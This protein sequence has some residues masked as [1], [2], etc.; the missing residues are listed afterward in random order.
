[1]REKDFDHLYNLEEK[2]W[3]F[4]GMRAIT[5]VIV[6]RE[7]RGRTLRILD[8]GCGTGYNI[9]H[10]EQGGHSVFA[11]DLAAE[12]ITGV[13]KRGFRKVCQASITDI[14]YRS[15]SFDVVFS[16]DV[17]Q[18]VSAELAKQAIREMY[19]VLKPG[20]HLYIRVAAFEWLRSSHDQEL[21][22]VHRYTRRELRARLEDAGFEALRHTYANTFLF[23]VV[24]LRRFVK[25]FGIGRGSDVKPLPTALAWVDPLFR[26]SLSI[27][28]R[29]LS[30]GAAFPF[31]LSVICYARRPERSGSIRKSPIE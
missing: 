3:W 9:R 28:A 4:V 27:E 10:Y 14:P 31:G 22:T 18:Q 11:L 6:D 1:M 23:P 15:E 13:Q 26:Q 5:D 21:Q 16:F 2:F 19:R 12:A 24:L 17:V 7:V 8:A 20:G 30:I 25:T 29:V